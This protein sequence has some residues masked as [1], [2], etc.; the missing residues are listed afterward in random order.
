MTRKLDIDK[1]DIK[2]L[3]TL[4][5]DGRITNQKLAERIALSPSACLERVRRLEKNGAIQEYQGVLDLTRIC[6]DLMVYAE[7]KLVNHRANDFEIFES[8]IQDIDEI[9]EC[10]A[11]GGGLDYIARFHVKNIEHYQKVIDMM[12]DRKLG[13]DQYFSYIITKPVKRFSGF[14]LSSLLN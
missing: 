3:E 12:L 8:G 11:V 9:V 1:I 13:I 7:I 6:Q 5:K 10:Y 4:Q 2:I 14:P